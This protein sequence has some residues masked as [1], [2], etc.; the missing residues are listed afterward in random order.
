MAR[1]AQI[2]KCELFHIELARK[3]LTS[4]T[5]SQPLLW[6]SNSLLWGLDETIATRDL[7]ALI[8]DH[9]PQMEWRWEHDLFE[10]HKYFIL[11]L[12]MQPSCSSFE[13]VSTLSYTRQ[14]VM[15]GRT[16]GKGVTI[17]G[18]D[19]QTLVFM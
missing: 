15:L 19:A 8:R 5:W 6:H 2:A 11:R 4:H 14:T 16:T 1:H 7:Q 3:W 12:L 17:V 13:T 18:T 10:L 9:L